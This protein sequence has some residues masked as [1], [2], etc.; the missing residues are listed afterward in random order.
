MSKS[1]QAESASMTGS[2]RSLWTNF[3]VIEELQAP[4]NSSHQSLHP[5]RIK[6]LW[7]DIELSD[8]DFV[9]NVGVR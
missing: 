3:F 7:Q 4:Q 8:K 9:R 5:F 2:V 6:V 1:T